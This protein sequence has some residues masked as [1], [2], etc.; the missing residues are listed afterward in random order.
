[1]VSSLLQVGIINLEAYLKTMSINYNFM[2]LMGDFLSN[3]QKHIILYN[4]L[5][6]EHNRPGPRLFVGLCVITSQKIDQAGEPE[7]FFKFVWPN[8]CEFV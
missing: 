1:V 5:K 2:A 6:F 8:G 7:A 3:A 4:G